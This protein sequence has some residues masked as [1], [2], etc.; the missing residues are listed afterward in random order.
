MKNC[1]RCGKE[2]LAK[3]RLLCISC[4]AKFKSKAKYGIATVVSIA[5]FV[6][7]KIFEGKQFKDGNDNFD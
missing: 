2:L 6:L 4:S 1:K 3:E 5:V 7:P